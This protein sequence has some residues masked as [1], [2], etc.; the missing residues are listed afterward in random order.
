MRE[1]FVRQLSQ[2]VVVVRLDGAGCVANRCCETAFFANG[3]GLAA[4]QN[5]ALAARYRAL[6]GEARKAGGDP[7]AEAVAEGYHKLLAYK[8]EYE[9]AR[10]HTEHLEAG[11]AEAFDGVRRIEFH[12]APPVFSRRGPDASMTPAPRSLVENLDLGEAQAGAQPQVGPSTRV[13]PKQ[14]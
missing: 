7:L 11:L 5:E 12:M 3:S 1:D 8:D 9:V 4:Y 10:L 2:Q 14:C 13:P 6:V